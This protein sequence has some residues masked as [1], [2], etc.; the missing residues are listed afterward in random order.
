MSQSPSDLSEPDQA[1]P[2]LSTLGFLLHDTARLL[3]KRF[4]Q[5]ARNLGLT[6][7][8]WQA[9]AFLSKCEGT[10]QG[11]LAD[12]LEL[13]PITLVRI[14]D[15][16]EAQGLIERRSHP[17]DRRIRLLYLTA[18]A[19]PLLGDMRAIGEATRGEAMVTLSQ[20]DRETLFRILTAMKSNLV[21]ACARP[22][23]EPGSN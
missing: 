18:E 8:Q 7:A 13:E 12:L 1:K 6:R 4:E 9:L 10:H 11:G 23:D 3:R 19:R 22:I 14:L 2:D 17:T 15:K 21:E 5:R 16:L 20:A